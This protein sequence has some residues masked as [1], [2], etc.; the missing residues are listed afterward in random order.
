MP[1]KIIDHNSKEY[2]DV[3]ALRYE[4]LRKP[5]G[6]GFT[7]DELADENGNIHIA[8][9]EDDELL[10]TCMLTPDEPGAVKLRQMAVKSG[11]QGK[12]IGRSI[13]RFAENISRDQGY[14]TL[15]M[16]AR[17]NV[18]DFYKKNGYTIS[19][20]EFIEVTIPHFKMEKKL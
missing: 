11:L 7:D 5:L 19:S 9:Y 10:G 15:H 12:G 18:V 8:A 6:L 17:K 20:D 2:F 13:I 16:S 4:L 14:Q 1:I 3:V